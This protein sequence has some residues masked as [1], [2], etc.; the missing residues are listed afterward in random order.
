MKLDTLPKR[1]AKVRR[2][3]LHNDVEQLRQYGEAGAKKT[4]QIKKAKKE[5][6]TSEM[7]GIAE[8]TNENVVPIDDTKLGNMRTKPEFRHPDL[9]K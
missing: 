5:A 3:I 8:A 4:N 2:A 1:P 7:Q 6:L 9:E